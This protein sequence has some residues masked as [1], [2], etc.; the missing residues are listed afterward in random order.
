MSEVEHE[1]LLK[2][3]VGRLVAETPMRARLFDEF[4]IDFCCGGKQ[5]LEQA[6]K[7]RGLDPDEVLKRLRES[8]ETV[9]GSGVKWDQATVSALVDHI[10]TTHHAYL[11][12]E[13]PRLEALAEKVAKVHGQRAPQMVELLAVF[14]RFRV[15]IDAHTMKEEMV[16]F[17]YMRQLDD[18]DIAHGTPPFGTVAN[19]IS[20]MESEH[21]EAA[22]ALHAMSTLT[23]GYT[24]PADACGS[25]KALVG[26]LAQLDSD[27]RTH[28]HKESN[29]LFPKAILLEKSVLVAG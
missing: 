12:S 7:N 6:C 26:G 20:C 24:Y 3:T 13:L 8:D 25:W 18:P 28:V 14:R 17:P 15:E 9:V 19:P 1:S 22:E 10:E 16:L 27:L 4:G 29:I 11:K 21:E 23:E 2:T 5:T